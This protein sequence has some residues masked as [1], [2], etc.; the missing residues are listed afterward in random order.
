MEQEIF[1]SVLLPENIVSELEELMKQKHEG[2]QIQVPLGLFI[3][4]ILRSSLEVEE[5]KLLF[6]SI[7]EEYSVEADKVYVRDNKRDVV[8][9][10]S[11][12]DQGELYC[13]IDGS[14]N[15]VHVGYAWSIPRV[16]KL[17][18]DKSA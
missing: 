13:N 16:R 5:A 4:E 14:K 11:F 7:L 10:L 2:R 18:L 15:C 1:R 12:K 6:P 8:A 3:G 9:E 17:I